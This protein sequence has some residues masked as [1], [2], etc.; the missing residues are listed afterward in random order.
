MAETAVLKRKVKA[1][2][3]SLYKK[4]FE[5]WDY[6]QPEQEPLIKING[7]L[8][9]G[10]LTVLEEELDDLVTTKEFTLW[11][12]TGW[13][14]WGS[15]G[16]GDQ[17]QELSLGVC[18]YFRT[19]KQLFFLMLVCTLLSIPQYFFLFKRDKSVTYHAG[20]E[21]G[22]DAMLGNLG[23]NQYIFESISYNATVHNMSQY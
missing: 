9:D 18:F 10:Q 5:H 13:F 22:F 20:P 15:R 4:I 21:F 23:W 11:T 14:G 7:L 2:E 12:A 3:N 8:G 6:Q 1:P 19:M 17:D 16:K